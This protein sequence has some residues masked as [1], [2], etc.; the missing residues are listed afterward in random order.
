MGGRPRW[1][2]VALACPSATSTEDIEAFYGSALGLA[3]E[4]GVTVVGGDTS[5]SPW[6]WI[7]NVFLLG[8]ARRP[9]LRSTARVGD[10]V[11][12]TGTLGRSHAGLALLDRSTPARSVDAAARADAVTAHLR[13]RARVQEGRWLAEAAGVTAMIDLSDGLATDLGHVTAESGVGARVQLDRVPIG[14]SA[15]TIAA[16]LADD[17]RVWATSGGEDYELLV[18]CRPDAYPGLADGLRRATG[19]ELT[20]VGEIVAAADGVQFVDDRGQ[21]IPVAP[22]FEHFVT[23]RAHG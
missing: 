12:V 8:T 1:A 20:D 10:I 22:G 15:R 5:A 2:L 14:T 19:T 9:V 13:P 4:Y 3:D 6:G 23:G 11:A 17:A 21:V 18:T 7:V 16:A